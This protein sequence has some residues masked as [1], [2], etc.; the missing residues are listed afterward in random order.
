MQKTRSDRSDM[1]QIP[2]HVFF[3][4]MEIAV[5]VTP[6]NRVVFVTQTG[7]IG[8]DD[9]TAKHRQRRTGTIPDTCPTGSQVC[10]LHRGPS[11]TDIKEQGLTACAAGTDLVHS[12]GPG[13]HS[14]HLIQMVLEG[15]PG[16]W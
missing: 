11:T 4:H 12:H 2:H 5:E 6:Q 13:G 14:R 16:R 9:L 15:Y 8:C 3:G 10:K 7:S 1:L